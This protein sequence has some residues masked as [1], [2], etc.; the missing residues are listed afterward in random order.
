MAK[1]SKQKNNDTEILFT[2]SMDK[3]SL[4]YTPKI[5]KFVDE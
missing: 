1:V 5:S 4:F 3:V 2:I